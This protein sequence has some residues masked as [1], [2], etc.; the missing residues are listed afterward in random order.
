MFVLGLARRHIGRV[1]RTNAFEAMVSGEIH[2]KLLKCEELRKLSET[3]AP[4]PRGDSCTTHLNDHIGMFRHTKKSRILPT[5]GIAF[6]S[7]L[8][9]AVGVA[10]GEL[11]VCE[12][13][14]N[15][16]IG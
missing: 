9:S 1:A 4:L 10:V 15:G 12:L 6:E 3:T 16:N 8:Y 2:I 13:L 5:T 14:K 11:E 7:S